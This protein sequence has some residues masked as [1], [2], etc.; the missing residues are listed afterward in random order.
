M[1]VP[2]QLQ[3]PESKSDTKQEDMHLLSPEHT[4]KSR[5]IAMRINYL[6]QDRSDL[7]Y[8]GKEL[9]RGMQSPTHGHWQKLKRVARYLKLRP[10]VATRYEK[11][12]RCSHVDVW[13]DTDHAGCLRTR[14]S[15]NGG[16][17]QLGS[18]TLKTW[19][20]TQAVIALS[21]GESEYYGI[22]KG[23]SVLLGALSLFRDLGVTDTKVKS[24]KVGCTPTAA[25]ERA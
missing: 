25:Q 15:T 2:R 13:V 18:H 3:H 12:E 16:A 17:L 20:S 7:Q 11:Q 19:S 8:S 4:T 6:A 23:A 22:V 1:S 24:S 5:S 14:K 21:S 9:A 10:R